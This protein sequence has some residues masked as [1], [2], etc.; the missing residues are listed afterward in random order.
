MVLRNLDPALRQFNDD[1]R[2]M[3]NNICWENVE[4]MKSEREK[5]FHGLWY[6]RQAGKKVTLRQGEFVAGPNKIY[7]IRV[8]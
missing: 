6:D 2:G 1:V 5:T 3:F 8:P 4:V 7:D